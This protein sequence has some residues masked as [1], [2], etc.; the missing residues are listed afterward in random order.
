ME[1]AKK[2]NACFLELN[3]DVV[4]EPPS[5]EKSDKDSMEIDTILDDAN[6]L[7]LS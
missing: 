6:K 5:T 1:L 7:T 4:M 3:T 2:V